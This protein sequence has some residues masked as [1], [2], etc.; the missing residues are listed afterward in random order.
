MLRYEGGSYRVK[1][2]IG[3]E[4]PLQPPRAV[5]LGLGVSVENSTTKL[6]N[7][8]LD[9]RNIIHCVVIEYVYL[10]LEPK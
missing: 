2:V 9:L 3:A 5:R 4:F 10:Y 6:G 7:K 8:N 1:I